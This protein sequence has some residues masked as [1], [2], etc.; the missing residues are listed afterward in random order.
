MEDYILSKI[1]DKVSIEIKSKNINEDGSYNL[2]VN[3]DFNSKACATPDGIIK[4]KTEFQ[5]ENG[6][7]ANNV[8][9]VLEIKTARLDT[10]SEEAKLQYL[11][12]LQQ[13]MAVS[14]LDYGMIVV[15][16][17]NTFEKTTIQGVD[18]D[19]QDLKVR[20]I[21]MHEYDLNQDIEDLIDQHFDIK[22]FYY[23]KDNYIINMISNC[24]NKFWQ[25]FDNNNLP[26]L[27]TKDNFL[28]ANKIKNTN[29]E[30]RNI[31]KQFKAVYGNNGGDNLEL[32]G[33]DD[34]QN[35]LDRFKELEKQIELDKNTI[36]TFSYNEIIKA[37]QQNKQ[38]NRITFGKNGKL[39]DNFFIKI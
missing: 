34:L 19:Y 28:S 23:K 29:T 2:I 17:P 26:F 8:D 24:I 5:T 18:Y 36:L 15:M 39:Q 9:A 11:F 33:F 7:I 25:D 27:S 3:N 6:E 12:Q 13:Q 35:K 21:T 16:Q 38:I 22:I 4:I 31:V 10:T 20:I 32:E 14:N 30:I 1:N 37:Y